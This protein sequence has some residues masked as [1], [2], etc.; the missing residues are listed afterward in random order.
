MYSVLSVF[1]CT[2]WWPS[3]TY[4][5]TFFFFHIIMLHHKWLDTVPRATQQD[6]IAYQFQR[7]Y[8]TTKTPKFPIHPIPSPSPLATT[9]LFSKFMI[10]FSLKGSF[11]LYIRFQIQEISYGTC[12][13]ISDLLHLVWE[14]L[15]PSM[16]LQMALFCS[17]LWLSSIPLC[18]YSTSP[19]SS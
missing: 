7:Q 18:I 14:S 10:F 13:S 3:Y 2:A 8:A 19:Y 4:M 15:V 5:H 6:L 17:F 16:L 1:Y 9:G 11:V 12:F